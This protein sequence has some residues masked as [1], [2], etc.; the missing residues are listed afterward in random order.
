MAIVYFFRC[1]VCKFPFRPQNV[2]AIICPNCYAVG[3]KNH[4]SGFE[5]KAA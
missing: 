5:R 2:C 4:F 1:Y 3:S